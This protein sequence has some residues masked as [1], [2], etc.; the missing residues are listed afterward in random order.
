MLVY[1]EHPVIP[2]STYK[3]QVDELEFQ[4]L[5]GEST[6]PELSRLLDI[7]VKGTAACIRTVAAVMAKQ[8]PQSYT[9]RTGHTRSLGRGSIVMLSSAMGYAA[10]P[11]RMP[12]VTAK[13]AMIGMMKSAGKFYSAH[14]G[15]HSLH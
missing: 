3:H 4:P 9:N 5:S 10:L 7:H 13:H 11:A 2:I 14:L 1:A 8:E 15:S 6:L 12:Y